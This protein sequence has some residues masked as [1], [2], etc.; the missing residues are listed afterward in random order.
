MRIHGAISVPCRASCVAS[1]EHCATPHATPRTP[2]VDITTEHALEWLRERRGGG[3][4]WLEWLTPQQTQPFFLYVA[5]TVPHAGGWG[6]TPIG[7]EHGAP[8]PTDGEYASR[9]EWPEVE[10]DHAAVVTYLDAKVGELMGALEALK[11][12]ESTLVIFAS[13]NGAHHEGGH[14]HLFFNSTGGLSG[15]KRSLYEGGVRSPTM[16]RWP[17]TVPAGVSPYRWAFWDVL[18]TF[19]ELAGLEVPRGLDGVSIVP[20]L[21]GRSQPAHAL[22]YWTWPGEYEPPNLPAGWRAEQRA[23]G[24]LIYVAPSGRAQARHPLSEL[25]STLDDH[26]A[27]K[28]SLPKDVVSGFAVVSGDWKGIVPHCAGLDH[29]PSAADLP[30][31]RVFHLPSDWAETSDLARTARGRLQAQRLLGLVLDANLS[32]GCYQC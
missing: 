10:R 7:P 27:A 6:H 12:E 17:G 3:E 32:C 20:T 14:S 22:L 19:A 1:D 30:S 24:T 31:M 25:A 5:F 26:A 15:H 4:G 8:V 23:A 16:A 11:L 29:K 28:V 13:D 21:M 2:Q 9:S 18:P